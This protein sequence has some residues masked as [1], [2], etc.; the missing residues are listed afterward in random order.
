MHEKEKALVSMVPLAH[1]DPT[2]ELCLYTD[3]SQGFWGAVLTQPDPME[4]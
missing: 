2:A 4:L 1:P 3:A